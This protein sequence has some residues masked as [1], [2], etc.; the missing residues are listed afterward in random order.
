MHRSEIGRPV[1]ADK[2][3]NTNLVQFQLLYH[4]VISN[5]RVCSFA[6]T[7]SHVHGRAPKTVLCAQKFI[8]CEGLI[9]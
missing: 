6:C 7:I 9:L 1:L 4:V 5:V 3:F 8:I 2:G